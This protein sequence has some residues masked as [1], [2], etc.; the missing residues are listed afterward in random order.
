MCADFSRIRYMLGVYKETNYK[1]LDPDAPEEAFL[2]R[3]AERWTFDDL[4][5]YLESV[6][7]TG[8][9]VDLISEY[10]DDC[11]FR[12]GKYWDRPIGELYRI[13][14]RTAEDILLQFV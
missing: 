7:E 13:A 6:W 11:Q 3:S 8:E 10:I 14:K 4:A 9:T 5:E 2:A 12:Y 1:V